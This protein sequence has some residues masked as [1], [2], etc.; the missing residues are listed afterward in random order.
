MTKGLYDS[1]LCYLTEDAAS[2]VQA[3]VAA[4][5]DQDLAIATLERVCGE[6]IYELPED[7]SDSDPWEAG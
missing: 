1:T 2:L 6:G 5:W 3:L 4:G 7:E